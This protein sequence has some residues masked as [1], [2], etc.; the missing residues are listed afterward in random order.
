MGLLPLV[1]IANS[2]RQMLH[3]VKVPVTTLFS[4]RDKVVHRRV[5]DMLSTA[6]RDQHRTVYFDKGGHEMLQDVGN[7]EVQAGAWRADWQAGR[8]A[9]AAR[10]EVKSILQALVEK[11]ATASKPAA[12]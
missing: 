4:K 3:K 5:P 1:N 11:M 7:E 6:L 2:T 12:E 10:A 9:D 8:D